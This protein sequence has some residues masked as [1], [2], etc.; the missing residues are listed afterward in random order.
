MG[1][2]KRQVGALLTGFLAVLVLTPTLVWGDI[3]HRRN[4]PPLEGKIIE[5][6]ATKVVLKTKFGRTEIKKSDI[7][8]IERIQ[9]K[10]EQ[11]QE[12]LA[13]L[14]VADIG[15]LKRLA[16]WAEDNELLKEAKQCYTRILR[17]DPE[18]RFAHRALGHIE[19]EGKWYSSQDYKK[20]LE[21]KRSSGEDEPR[22]KPAVEE[23]ATPDSS[24]KKPSSAG[25]E[26]SNQ[27]GR[28]GTDIGSIVEKRLGE[29]PVVVTS[30]HFR[31]ITMFE[32]EEAKTLLEL[33]EKVHADFV[34]MIGDR[35]GASYWTLT[36]DEFFLTSKGQYQEFLRKIMPMYVNNKAHID[37]LLKQDG[38]AISST[39]PIGASVRQNLPLRNNIVHHAA[40]HLIHNYV[41][42]RKRLA[43]WLTEGF[44]YYMEYKYEKS[45]R[46]TVRTDAM[47]G[48]DA[49]VAQKRSDTSTWPEFV[50]EMVIEGKHEPF[51]KWKHYFL[52]KLD[53]SHLAKSWSLMTFLITEHEDK[54]VK[55]LKNMRK[56]QWEEAMYKA[57]HWTNEEVDKEWSLWVKVTY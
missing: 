4:G 57:F 3:I 18:N 41:G 31:I 37:F 47:Y 9:S 5:E 45:I 40:K 36:A 35:E 27:S 55:W 28:G 6:T 14:K 12:R 8:R 44:A 23:P 32:E 49:K 30:K 42:P 25:S 24:D 46:V 15:G 50:K 38:N 48:D 39:P 19:H 26:K 29:R 7:L 13:K 1:I 33:A 54:F 34:E 11:F 2:V 56:M 53:H 43:A 16:L 17:L 51:E 20:L 21:S 10:K 52:N 22:V